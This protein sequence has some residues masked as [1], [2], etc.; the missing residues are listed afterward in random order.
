MPVEPDVVVGYVVN[1]TTDIY[2]LKPGARFHYCPTDNITQPGRK[3]QLALPIIVG[4]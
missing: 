2:V 1:K 4:L 3:Y